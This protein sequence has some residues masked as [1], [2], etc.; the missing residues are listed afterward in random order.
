MASSKAESPYAAPLDRTIAQYTSG[1]MDKIQQWAQENST[2]L[3]IALAVAVVIILVMWMSGKEGMTAGG[4]QELMQGYFCGGRQEAF[5]RNPALE[6]M[7]ASG[8]TLTKQ[9]E[10]EG[11]DALLNRLG[12]PLGTAYVPRAPDEAWGWLRQAA[13]DGKEG[14]YPR[15]ERLVVDNKLSE[16]L[17]GK[18]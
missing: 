16:I 1:T 15:R 12:C 3:L 5:Q 7:E 14:M 6:G 11:R 9:L 8:P 4:N 18:S 2:A 13:Y 10:L 17:A